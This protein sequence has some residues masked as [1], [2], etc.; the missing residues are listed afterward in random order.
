MNLY[1]SIL[2]IIENHRWSLIIIDNHCNIEF[3]TLLHEFCLHKKMHMV[4]NVYIYMNI[5]A[6]KAAMVFAAFSWPHQA[7]LLKS[8]VALPPTVVMM[9]IWDALD[10]L[11]ALAQSF[12]VP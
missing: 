5:C 1:D 10:A 7:D 3:W 2:L 12:S 4:Y 6:E 11:D 8:D 9:R